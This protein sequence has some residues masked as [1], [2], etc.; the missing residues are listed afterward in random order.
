LSLIVV[1]TSR[2]ALTVLVGGLLATGGTGGNGRLTA[3]SGTVAVGAELSLHGP[4][5]EL[6]ELLNADGT[7][8]ITTV[9][10]DASGRARVTLLGPP[11]SVVVYLATD[12]SAW[13]RVEVIDLA[14]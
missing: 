10:L 14:P 2:S 11:R 5:H 8:A 12:F 3:D 9:N 13:V 1:S 6:V 4:P 7:G